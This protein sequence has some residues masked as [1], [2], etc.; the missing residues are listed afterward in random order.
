MTEQYYFERLNAQTVTRG[1]RR[2]G[3][4]RSVIFAES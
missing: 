3:P 2:T 4:A 1:G